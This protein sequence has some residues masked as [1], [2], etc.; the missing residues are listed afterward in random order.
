M[1]LNNVDTRQVEEFRN[2]ITR[3]P[4]EAKVTAKI[5]GEW[6]FEEGGPQFRSVV[7]VKDG[8]A[9]LEMSHPNFAGPGKY[10]SPMAFG[11][12][13]FASCF[14]STFVTDA[15]MQGITLD[16]V[17]TKVEA[18]L[19]YLQQFDISD[20]PLVTGYRVTLEVK[21]S[22]PVETIE[23]LKDHALKVCMGM[24]TIVHAIPLKAELRIVQ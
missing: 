17:K 12:F 2:L 7:K 18:D 19:N 3:D 14:T 15:S 23:A 10:P 1:S 24:Y 4:S 5:E 8:T 9:V 16:S 21:S 11:L 20:D 22:S 13:W 6:V